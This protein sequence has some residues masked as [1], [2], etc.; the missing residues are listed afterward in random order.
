[1]IFN[2]RLTWKYMLQLNYWRGPTDAW[3]L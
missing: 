1:M 2:D 3:P